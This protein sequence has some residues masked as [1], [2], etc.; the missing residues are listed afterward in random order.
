MALSF[1]QGIVALACLATLGGALAATG[2]PQAYIVQLADAPAAA[3]RGGVKGL[4][5]TQVPDGARLRA[6]DAKVRA[7]VSHLE[8]R[9]NATLAALGGGVKLLHAYNYSF[10]GFAA[11]LTDA[12]VQRLRGLPGV[13]AV[14][15]DTPRE[16]TTSY[17]PTFLGLDGPHGV[18]TAR[19]HGSRLRGEDVIIGVI[20]GGVQPEDASFADRQDAKGNPTTGPGS[21]VYGAPPAGWAGSCTAGPGFDPALHCNHK[22]IGAQAFDASFQ[23]TGLP[24][25]WDEFAGSPRDVYGHGSHTASTA[26]GNQGV[27][28]RSNGQ[29]VGKIS[30]MAPR[31]RI[32]AYKVCWNWFNDAIGANQNNC[33]TGD[34]MAAIDAAVADGVDVINYSISGS[35]TNLMDPVEIAFLNAAAAG[36]FVTASA[37]NAGPGNTT[38]HPS[39]WITTVAASTHDRFLKADATL[40]DG[41]VYNGASMSAGL[42]PT[43]TI[44]S[45]D[46]QGPKASAEDARLCFVGGLDPAKVAGKVVVCDRGTS[47]RTDKSLAVRKAGGVGMIL[48]NAPITLPG[49][50]SDTLN[51]D[52]HWVPTVHLPQANRDAVRAY[53]ALPGS[54][55]ALGVGTQAPGI[56][57]PVMADFSS[58]G[59]N[60]A[61]SDVIKPDITAPG[62]AV[63]AAYATPQADQ[64]THDAI[65]AGTL[66]PKPYV[67]YLQGTSMSSPHI[68]GLAALL[69]QQ[70]PTMSPSKIKSALMTSA[71]GV[72]L[73]DGSPDNNLNGYGAGHANPAG[74]LNPGLVY[75]INSNDY[76]AYLC[77]KGL[78]AASDPLCGIVGSLPGHRLNLP[79]FSG[80]VPGSLTFERRVSNLA[81]ARSYTATVSVPGFDATVSPTT[82][83][84]GKDGSAKFT[85]TLKAN[86]AALGA[87]SQGSLVWSDGQHVVRSPILARSTLFAGPALLASG[88]ASGGVPAT[89][90]FGFTGPLSHNVG[91]LTEATR[92]AGT[93]L[94]SPNAD[95][96]AAC[97]ANEVGTTTFS[98]A[99][100]AGTLVSRFALYDADTSSGGSD[101]LD[102]NVYNAAGTRVGSSGGA[103]ANEMVTLTSPA[104]G[105]YTVCVHG[106]AP[107]DGVST[108]FT[109]S[110]WIVTPGGTLLAKGLPTSVTTGDSA[111]VRLSWK[112]ATAGKRYLGALGLVQGAD[113]ATG[114]PLGVT[115]LS[116]EPGV[117]AAEM[118]LPSARKAAAQAAR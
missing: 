41:S 15:L 46:A 82:L 116:V 2:K 9:R 74:A 13:V 3:Y 32:A 4:A 92:T 115:V 97:R 27:N 113:P 83:S 34:S 112:N 8:A 70:W 14:T 11:R 16:L 38:A 117:M 67:A 37:G 10:N 35:A 86:G 87:W 17:T 60:L 47:A 69:K 23:S 28:A 64:A 31:A 73:A 54:T 114:T 75:P 55:A 79:S 39:P 57:A 51:D 109:L 108:A 106:Y 12:Q 103:T 96:D 53:A 77:G 91:G 62:V 71:G 24:I 45:T 42:A 56:V 44:L 72:K 58:R 61:V 22:L 100:P 95:G 105:D 104:A 84:V 1:K 68:A 20:D 107:A 49:G 80:D 30:G 90:Q 65:G 6:S 36:V 110:S 26:A 5:A 29:N 48:L 21:V 66:A 52:A 102:M 76:Y 43:S 25:G 89:Y 19:A 101:D 98:F 111:K 59:P 99:V 118:G 18:W 7:Y 50:G 88:L 78:V 94:K 40:G 63:L 33:W 93:V 81:S 85:L